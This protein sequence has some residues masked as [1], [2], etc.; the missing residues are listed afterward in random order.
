MSIP[1]SKV[2]DET[3]DCERPLALPSG[4]RHELSAV[5]QSDAATIVDALAGI[6][7]PHA[8][9]IIRPGPATA[10]AQGGEVSIRVSHPETGR[11]VS[12]T[13]KGD[14]LRDDDVEADLRVVWE[15]G[16]KLRVWRQTRTKRGRP[17]DDPEQLRADFRERLP[18]AWASAK[19]RR[20]HLPL[21]AE[22]I[23]CELGMGEDT[24]RSRLSDAGLTLDQVKRGQF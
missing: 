14:L 23:A 6:V 24:F 3:D 11:G 8:P 21:R 13:S 10:T 9:V 19:Q 18:D 4:I 16:R 15:L 20:R 12:L 22:D 2:D 1:N 7:H 5:I 17:A